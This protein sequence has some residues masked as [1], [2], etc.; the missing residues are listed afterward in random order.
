MKLITNS[1]TLSVRPELVR[2]ATMARLPINSDVNAIDLNTALQAEW[3]KVGKLR[4]EIGGRPAT[5]EEL[6]LF[7]ALGAVDAIHPDLKTNYAGGVAFA[8]MMKAVN[9]R[10]GYLISE[11][12]AG[13]KVP[14]P[15]WFLAGTRAVNLDQEGPEC[16][17]R[18]IEETGSSLGGAWRLATWPTNEVE[19]VGFILTFNGLS[20]LTPIK[21]L[22]TTARHPDGKPKNP[23][24]EETVRRWLIEEPSDGCYLL[25]SSQPWCWNQLQ[26]TERIA[27]EKGRLGMRFRVCGPAAP[28]T[29]KFE[30]YLDDLAR[31]LKEELMALGKIQ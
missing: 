24:T 23:N 14:N 8:G 31:R 20:A 17:S 2:L 16:V 4:V 19:V 13:L 28:P 27:R 25:V 18:I 30:Q 12:Q 22:Q 10:V 9:R 26:Q 15:F 11:I 21:V 29:I 5:G 3:F 7:R 6:E 1:E